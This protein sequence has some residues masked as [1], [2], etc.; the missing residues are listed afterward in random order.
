MTDVPFNQK[1][2]ESF[3]AAGAALLA[4]L[5]S[6]LGL[7]ACT[8]SRGIG[9]A[10]ARFKLNLPVWRVS[11]RWVYQVVNGFNASVVSKSAY[12]VSA[13]NSTGVEISVEGQVVERYNP[14][15]Q[16]LGETTFGDALQYNSA[17]PWFEASEKNVTTQSS[18]RYPN[19]STPAHDW[20]QTVEVV[21][22]ETITVPA[23]KFNCAVIERRIQFEHPDRFRLR[24]ERTDRIW[25]NPEVRR[26]VQREVRGSYID[27]SDI[28]DKGSSGR[29]QEDWL[30]WQLLSFTSAPIL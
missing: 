27:S 19:N 3:S 22:F 5:L 10:L 20:R 29:R 30:I 7:G 21:G 1:K 17:V 18:T 24:S 16:L 4:P 23:G 28:D 14:Q 9:T 8:S 2:R 11:E 15:L 26:W 12:I 6:T 25:Y 13:S